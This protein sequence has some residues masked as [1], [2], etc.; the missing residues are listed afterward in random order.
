MKS[1]ISGSFW[2]HTL[3]SIMP[4]TTDSSPATAGMNAGND[5]A[6]LLQGVSIDASD[7]CM[8]WQCVPPQGI[9]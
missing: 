1:E 3:I 8:R 6:P 5:N 2:T 4:K 9:S 7:Y